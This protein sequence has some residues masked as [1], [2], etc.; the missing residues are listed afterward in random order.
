MPALRLASDVKSAK[1]SVQP[2]PFFLPNAAL[3]D[4]GGQMHWLPVEKLNNL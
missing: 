3:S 1:K 2:F 4:S